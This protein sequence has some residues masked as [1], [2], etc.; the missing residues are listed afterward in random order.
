MEGIYIGTDLKFLITI[1][2]ANF[3]METDD[4]TVDIVRGL[5]RLHF[6]KSDLVVEEYTETVNNEEVTKLHYYVCFDSAELGVGVVYAIVT[7]YVPD[8]DF[9]DGL[10]TE[11]YKIE[12]CKMLTV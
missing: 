2:A 9:D 4:F 1:E 10:R 7:A 5:N 8:D 3:D 11:V 12:L 6:D